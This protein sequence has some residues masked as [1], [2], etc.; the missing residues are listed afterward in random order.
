MRAKRE[1][2][3]YPWLARLDEIDGGVELTQEAEAR[4][5]LGGLSDMDGGG[6]VGRQRQRWW[7]PS[8]AG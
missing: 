3:S 7:W 5:A 4:M 8:G 2:E 6:R 1:R